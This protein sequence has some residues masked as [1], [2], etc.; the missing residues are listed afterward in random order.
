MTDTIHKHAWLAFRRIGHEIAFKQIRHGIVFRQIQ[1]NQYS[2]DRDRKIKSHFMIDY[3]SPARDRQIKRHFMTDYYS[4]ARDKFSDRL[5][6][7][8]SKSYF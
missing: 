4:L 8:N 6:F 5:L 1:T 2:P 7:M 3:Y